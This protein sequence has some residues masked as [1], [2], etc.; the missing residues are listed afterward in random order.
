MA[1]FL[2]GGAGQ[3]SRLRRGGVLELADCSR[4]VRLLARCLLPF[5][6]VAALP[7]AV[8]LQSG[9][10]ASTHNA[11]PSGVLGSAPRTAAGPKMAARFVYPLKVA[12]NRRYLVDR[13][14][15][16]FLIVGDS[17]QALI[18][19]LTEKEAA[20]YLANRH[21]AGFNAVWVNLL[22]NNYTGGRPDGTT[23]DGL[24]PFTR[25]GDLA[26]PNDS[27]FSRVDR[28]VRLAAKYGIVVFLD[29]I[30]TGGWLDVLKTNGSSKDYAFGRYLGTRYKKFP[31][32]VWLNGNDF[33]S[34]QDP[35]KDAVVLAVARGIKAA[36]PGHIQTLELNYLTSSSLDDSRWRP[37]LGLDAAYTYYPTYAEV[38]KEYGRRDFLPIFMI[39]ASYE[40][41]HDYTGPQ[42][43]RR[44]EYWSLLSGA[45]GQFYGNKFTWQFI[46][47]WQTHLDTIG[48]RQLGYVTQLFA[49]RPW[50]KLIPDQRHK[51]VTAGFGTF[52]DTGSVNASDYVTAASTQDGKLAFAYLPTGGTI[53][54]DTRRLATPVRARWY[55]PTRGTYR[56]VSGSPFRKTGLT[57]FTS[58]GKNADRDSDWVLVLTRS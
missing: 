24:R 27:Y 43:L 8:L 30:E 44:Q 51:I 9:A 22:C 3:R 46:E 40:F 4:R 13:R 48:S 38:L 49:G 42:T 6:A 23:Y 34:W 25:P 26:T 11:A 55:D 45:A 53:R 28:I 50:F 56:A 32:I 54:V 29:P 2:N 52:A 58:P 18:A 37:L 33:Q 15:T 17:P 1:S 21:A 10:S 19:N 14:G 12:A 5:V 35:S 39:E 57:S 47:D 31:N 20:M 7:A 16:P 36:D 41:E